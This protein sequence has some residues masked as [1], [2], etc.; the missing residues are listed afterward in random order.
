MTTIVA[1]CQ[2][3]VQREDAYDAIAYSITLHGI[4]IGSAMVLATPHD[5]YLER[6]DIDA[7]HRS[8]GYG[9]DAISQLSA[10]HPALYAAPD[11]SASQ[12]LLARIGQETTL[13]SDAC[14]GYGVYMLLW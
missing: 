6:I 11:N 9:S 1:L 4:P 10:I 5:A 2:T 14:Q 13:Y 3:R 8:C 7:E 12:R